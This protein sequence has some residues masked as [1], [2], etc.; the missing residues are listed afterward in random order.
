MVGVVH[1]RLFGEREDI[2]EVVRLISKAYSSRFLKPLKNTR[3]PGWRVF[4]DVE[5][6][7]DD[8]GRSK[9]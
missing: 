5:V 4:G 3:D 1:V 6:V 2:E 9:I 7:V 8:S